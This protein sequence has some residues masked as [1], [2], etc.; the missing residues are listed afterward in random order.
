MEE[1]NV[2]SYKVE[3]HVWE[4]EKKEKKR[5]LLL[6][7]GA[8]I[9][10]VTFL[11][12]SFILGYKIGGSPVGIQSSNSKL[13]YIQKIMS[14]EWYF[15]DN[16][17]NI[18][19]ELE[20]KAAQGMTSFE[21][22]QHTQYLSAE[23]NEE[24]HKSLRGSFYG[25]GVQ[26]RNIGDKHVIQKVFAKSPAEK[27]GL[28]I[29]DI[30]IAV[31]GTS[32]VGKSSSEF[33]NLVRGEKGTTVTLKII[34]NGIEQEI[35]IERDN[36]STTL[37]SSII[38]NVGIVHLNGFTEDGGSQIEHVFTNFQNQNV[39][40]V[41]IDLRDNGGGYLKTTLDIAG[42]LLPKDTV[43]LKQED[44]YHS[45]KENKTT[46][47]PR[48][49]FKKV[50]ILI[51]ENSASASEVLTAAL[52]EQANI[53]VVGVKSFG[54]G[55]VQITRDFNDGSALKY[56]VAQWITPKG[57]RINKV[58]VMPD[59]VVEQNNI[60]TMTITPFDETYKVDQVSSTIQQAQL[61][62]KF[63]DFA[64]NRTDG[65]FDNST[66]T[67]IKAYQEYKQLSPTGELTQD[68]L[69]S[70]KIDADTK[71][72]NNLSVYDLQLKKALEIASE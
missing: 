52:K 65:Y 7:V 12:L 18:D 6:K 71:Y 42:L 63:L 26:Y 10:V 27:A 51:N 48:F 58:G 61:L 25:I 3:K 49:N 2:I 34:R 40:R 24:I 46:T 19:V 11:G 62:L 29:N 15:S 43:V 23:E 14:N 53:P 41:I 57:N 56:T 55:T 31:D 59:Y 38:S 54:K 64:P 20:N 21:I 17:K 45:I 66:E 67:S 68:L 9:A 32:I 47:Q 16:I 36:I 39:D 5:K 1:N 50:V 30:V 60:E 37:E 70:L 69:V 22:D 8:S 33:A 44:V 72:R 13:S 35:K 28:K 4:D